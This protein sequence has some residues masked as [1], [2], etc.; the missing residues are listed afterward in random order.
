ME[1]LLCIL[2]NFENDLTL[3]CCRWW[4][5]GFFLHGS[6][7][8]NCSPHFSVGIITGRWNFLKIRL[9]EIWPW[10][11]RVLLSDE[12]PEAYSETYQISNLF[13]KI[14]DVWQRFSIHFWDRTNSVNYKLF[15]VIFYSTRYTCSH[16][17]EKLNSKGVLF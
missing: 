17:N 12:D 5:I 16:F 13:A 3:G 8:K 7:T 9:N 14:V 6:P 1:S 4:W 10:N 11:G 2:N 15:A